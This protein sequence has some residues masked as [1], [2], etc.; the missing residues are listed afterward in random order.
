ML[1]RAPGPAAPPWDRREHRARPTPRYGADHEPGTPGVRPPPWQHSSR[2]SASSSIPGAA[3]HAVDT[4][5]PHRAPIP[6]GALRRHAPKV[7]AQCGSPARSDL[8]G[9]PP[10]RAVPTATRIGSRRPAQ[11]AAARLPRRALP[12]GGRA[13]RSPGLSPPQPLISKA[14]LGGI[15]YRTVPSS[16]R[17]SV[18]LSVAASRSLP[19][20]AS[21]AIGFAEPRPGDR[22]PE[23]GAYRGRWDRAAGRT[24]AHPS[25]RDRGQARRPARRE[26]RRRRAA[27]VL[28]AARRRVS[29]G[30]KSATRSRP[31]GGCRCSRRQSCRAG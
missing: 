12:L 10:A 27:V 9:G 19:A 22:S 23:S 2:P 28:V 30:L 26:H 18:P 31:T 11:R 5:D 29:Y 8:R 1:W 13:R 21:H 17:S 7:G 24:L 16:S 3:Q 14:H 4:P 25:R 20:V 15:R 6:A